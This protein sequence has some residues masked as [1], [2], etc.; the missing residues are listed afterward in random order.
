[1]A[2]FVS[3]VSEPLQSALGYGPMDAIHDEFHSL[4]RGAKA[5]TDAELPARLG[6]IVDHLKEH[7]AAEERWMR[8][9]NYPT[10][11]C[12]IAEHQAVLKSADELAALLGTGK[13]AVSRAFV[14]ELA[15]WFPAHSDYL[16]S[17]LAHWICKR[18]HGGKP[19][20]L[21]RRHPVTENSHV[22]QARGP[23]ARH[24]PS[25]AVSA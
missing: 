2:A 4:L 23:L 17:A 11:D 1:M 15:S 24:M 16:D 3:Q 8:D 14:N 18:K 6:L 25:D 22:A 21:N 9:T 13:T 12:H 7:F 19:I 5:C 20:V 10:S